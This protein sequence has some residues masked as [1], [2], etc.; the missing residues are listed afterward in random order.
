MLHREV[1][2]AT[3]RASALAGEPWQARPLP[4]CLLALGRFIDRIYQLQLPADAMAL[5]D[6][7]RRWTR[8]TKLALGMWK[9]DETL[10][11]RCPYCEAA[12]RLRRAGAEGFLRQADHGL[13]LVWQEAGR[14]WCRAC[15]RAWEKSQWE[16]LCSLIGQQRRDRL[17][18]TGQP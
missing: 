9:P 2:P 5:E 1:P 16:W 18:V 4:G 7:V 12:P 3:A 6:E 15:G 8:E 14:I 13:V 17:A 11:V 10:S